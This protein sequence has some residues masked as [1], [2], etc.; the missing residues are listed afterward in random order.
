MTDKSFLKQ[1][2]FFEILILLKT[3]SWAFSYS[4]RNAAMILE[5]YLERL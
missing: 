4:G 3:Q 5:L 2:F 1:L